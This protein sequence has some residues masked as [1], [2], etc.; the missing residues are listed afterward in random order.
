MI[1]RVLEPEVM[2]TPQEA[3]DYNAMDHTEVNRAFVDDLL[4]VLGES[5]RSL[6]AASR[7]PRSPVRVLDVGT[8]TALIPIELCRR[9]E[10]AGVVVGVDLAA[11]ML[12]L[13]RRNIEAAALKPRICVELLD[14]KSLRCEAATFDVVMSNSIVHHI[15][16]PLVV[17]REMV[18]VLKAPGVLFVRDL[19]RP[20]S[21]GRVEQIVATYA[22]GESP[23]SQQLFR[24]SLWAALT[25]GEI[26]EL[27][28]ACGLPRNS[29]RQ[30]SDRHWTLVWR[31]LA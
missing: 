24:Q 5:V 7:T 13:A 15:P 28:A 11:E 31:K 10:F 19:L 2:D 12:T 3:A 9:E 30:S 18:R 6:T 17:M 23:H 22:A 14:A 21:D 29:V 26:Q 4:A 1:P 20:N 25:V 8:G 16:D 27:A